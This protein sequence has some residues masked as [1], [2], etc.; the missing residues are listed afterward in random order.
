MQVI[1]HWM[2]K[3]IQEGQRITKAQRDHDHAFIQVSSSKAFQA[4]FYRAPEQSRPRVIRHMLTVMH[5]T[6]KVTLLSHASPDI[7]CEGA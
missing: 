2:V 7:P 3:L 4:A 5:S 6:S 1:F